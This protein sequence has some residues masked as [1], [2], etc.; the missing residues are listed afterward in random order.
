MTPIQQARTGTT[1]QAPRI[2]TI[3]DSDLRAALADG[4]AD[5]RE[6]RGDILIV[7]FAYPVV[8]LLLSI[9]ALGHRLFPV[10]FPLAAGITLLG[11]AVAT[12]FYELARRRERGLDSSWRHFFDVFVQPSFGAIMGLT[13][14][15]T[16]LFLLWLGTAWTVYDATLGLRDP[17]SVG[18]FV[19]LL[20]TTPEGW[21][22]IVIGNLVGLI[23]ALVTLAISAVSFP[24]LV[25]RDVDAWTAVE[26]SV[27]AMGR[28][29]VAMLKWGFVVA[30]LLAIGSLPFFVGLAVVLPWLGYATWHLYTRVVEPERP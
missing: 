26:T 14:F 22:M 8:G 9:F 25:D 1:G 12:G 2:R 6:K 29:P 24:M 11:P 20:F 18:S 5:F 4:W 19:H 21:S 15:L 27:R 7:G 16:L 17:Q 3:D 13:L 28:N 10:L 30:V 23:F